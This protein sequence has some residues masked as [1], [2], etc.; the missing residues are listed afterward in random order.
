MVLLGCSQQ[1]QPQQKLTTP[2]P[3]QTT[4]KMENFTIKLDGSLDD[5]K[6]SG[7]APLIVEERNPDIPD[8]ANPHLVY[9]A[10]DGNFV[11]VAMEIFGKIEEERNY[12]VLIYNS[13][14]KEVLR[15]KWDYVERRF[16]TEYL[17][18]GKYIKNIE[19]YG[20]KSSNVLEIASKSYHIAKDCDGI[21]VVVSKKGKVKA[22][23]SK[24]ISNKVSEI[25]KLKIRFE[26][27]VTP[28]HIKTKETEG[29]ENFPSNFSKL[30]EFL[31]TP[32]KLSKFMES[33]FHYKYHSGCLAYSPEEFFELRGGDCKDYAVFSS[34]ILNKHGYNA[35]MLAFRFSKNGKTDG[36]V[37]TVFTTENGKLQYISFA[38]IYGDFS[39][40]DE[41]LEKEKQR[42]GFDKM[43]SYR[44]INAGD[45][46][47]CIE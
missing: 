15:I 19:T 8:S 20:A 31:D 13:E 35:K 29:I 17:K 24:I 18:D 44:L 32:E 39:S 42:I 3:I 40:I 27:E 6:N 46:N 7:V 12:L 5:W 4:P 34:Y 30:V 2:T 37:I 43:I 21:K 1:P 33:Y 11:Y 41:I 36:H 14:T 9:L 23:Y 25:P 22:E 10:A 45:T 47:T 38:K 16:E 28:T 26:L